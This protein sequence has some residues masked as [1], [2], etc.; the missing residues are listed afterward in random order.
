MYLH[1]MY[2]HNK[3]FLGLLKN[4]INW[5]E[6]QPISHSLENNTNSSVLKELLN[7]IWCLPVL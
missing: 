7:D 6:L 1:I 2:E 4:W 5:I 3:Y